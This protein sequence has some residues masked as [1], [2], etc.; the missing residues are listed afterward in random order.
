M[1]VADRLVLEED[2]S[3]AAAVSTEGSRVPWISSIRQHFP[4][5][6]MVLTGWCQRGMSSPVAAVKSSA[7]YTL[8][9]G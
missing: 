3:L 5:K 6:R 8:A 4:E 2:D 1:T 7:Y 9:R